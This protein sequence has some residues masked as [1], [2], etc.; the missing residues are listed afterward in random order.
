MAP[1]CDHRTTYEIMNV[2]DDYPAIE[3]PMPRHGR[4][5]QQH[6]P[7]RHLQIECRCPIQ[8]RCIQRLP[9]LGRNPERAGRIDAVVGSWAVM[10]RS[11]SEGRF[12]EGRRQGSS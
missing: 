11:G 5:V 12:R 1:V 3:A 4:S 6:R 8:S 2:L 10:Y 9:L 7:K